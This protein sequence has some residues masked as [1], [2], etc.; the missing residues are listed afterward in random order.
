MK[1]NL[2]L[3]IAVVGLSLTTLVSLATAQGR[4]SR[5]DPADQSHP[6]KSKDGFVDFTLKQINSSDK[7][8]GECVDEGR[9]ML[10][11]ESIENGYFWSNLMSLGLLGC[12]CFIIIYQHRIQV[13]REGTGA[14][15]LAQYEHALARANAQAEDATKQNHGLMEALTALKESALRPQALTQDALNGPQGQSNRTRTL[16]TQTAQSAQPKNGNTSPVTGRSRSAASA[17]EPVSQIGL[18]KQDVDLVMKVN[19]LEQQ[20]DRSKD[21]SSLLRRQLNEAEQRVQAEQQKNRTL[22]GE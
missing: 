19:S 7:D 5:Y 12:L 17:T 20:L 15:M 11:E 9:K 10:L 21:Q 4:R 18:F 8:F 14:E 22:K 1:V 16:A 2:T 3:R 13:R 6:P